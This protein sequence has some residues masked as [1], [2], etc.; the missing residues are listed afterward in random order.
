[1]GALVIIGIVG[2][3]VGK[4]VESIHQESTRIR[5]QHRIDQLENQV[6]QMKDH[7]EWQTTC[8]KRGTVS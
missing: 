5:Y 7:I 3:V 8:I 2:V 1:M 6:D 4:A